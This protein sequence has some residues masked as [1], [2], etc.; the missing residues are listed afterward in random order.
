MTFCTSDFD[1]EFA[2]SDYKWGDNPVPGLPLISLPDGTLSEPLLAVFGY[3]A[4]SDRVAISSLKPEAFTNR[5]WLVF[6]YNKGLSLFDGNDELMIEFRNHL[7]WDIGSNESR[8][9]R[10]ST[11]SVEKNKQIATKM[12]HV[13]TLYQLLPLAIPFGSGGNR[14]PVFIGPNTENRNHPITFKLIWSR[15]K[16]RFIQKWFYHRRIKSAPKAPRATTIKQSERLYTFL[17]GHAFRVQ[18]KKRLPHAPEKDLIIADRNWLMAKTMAGGGL[19]CA[20][21]GD[22]TKIHIAEALFDAGIT[23]TIVDLDAISD[24]ERAKKLI[25]AKVLSLQDGKEYSFL[26]VRITGKGTKTRYIPFQIQ[27]ICDLLEAGIWG[28]RRR[29]IEIWKLSDPTYSPPTHIFLSFQNKMALDEGTIGD[30]IASGFRECMIK[31]SAH[32]L[33]GL[34]ATVTAAAM[35]REYFAQNQYR[36]DQVL[37]NTLLSDLARAMGHASVDTTVK[38]YIDKELHKHLTKIGT[39]SAKLFRRLWDV[40]VM[41]RRELSELRTELLLKFADRLSRSEDDSFFTL[42]TSAMLDDPRLNPEA[43][44]PFDKPQLAY[45]SSRTRTH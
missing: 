35:W 5:Q 28:C 24:D 40:L 16:K 15:K 8:K 42:A 10:S 45:D 29:Q 27:T 26:S 6:L 11:A 21:V 13:F 44:R 39:N 32:K 1:L 38:Y 14:T 36:F 31:S 33:R 18:K 25:V 4:V 41:E 7:G 30:I 43:F 37:I 20:E 17:R 19:R 23:D 12:Q 34:F 22:L 9:E 3:S 2:T